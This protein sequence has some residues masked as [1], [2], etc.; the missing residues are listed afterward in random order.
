MDLYRPEPAA[1]Q[2]DKQ[3]LIE[4]LITIVVIWWCTIGSLSYY[5]MN[6]FSQTDSICIS[7]N[8]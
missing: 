3:V 6:I 4:Y 5:F 1:G 8:D 7:V 2:V